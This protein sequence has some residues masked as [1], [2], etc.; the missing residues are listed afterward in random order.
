MAGVS[1]LAKPKEPVVQLRCVVDSTW[2]GDPL[3]I[4]ER[5]EVQIELG[6]A[7]AKIEIDAPYH[8][9][10]SP[11]DRGSTP[12]LWDYEVVELFLLGAE[13]H[14]LE[15][16][17]GPHGHYLALE[18]RGVRNVVASGM[19]LKYQARVAGARWT[20]VA[21]VPAALIPPGMVALNAY[22]IHGL[23]TRRRYL[24]MAPVGGSVPDFHTLAAFW[25]IG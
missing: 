23:G 6:S 14:Y 22:A 17:F 21:H 15:L 20:G 25:P 3:G 7:G 18:L 12:Q 24:A 13:E 11:P 1:L 5:V 8:G 19:A 9:D 16:E 10:P 2:D 4:D